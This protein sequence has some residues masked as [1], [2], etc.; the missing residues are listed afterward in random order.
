MIPG[1]GP[2][3]PD[4]RS[5]WN[6]IASRRSP[7]SDT[8]RQ[9][10]PGIVPL[11]FPEHAQAGM[12]LASELAGHRLDGLV[13]LGDGAVVGL[14]LDLEVGR[15]EAAQRELVGPV[16]DLVEQRE[17]AHGAHAGAGLPR[18]PA[19]APCRAPAAR[20][21]PPAAAGRP[22][23]GARSTRLARRRARSAWRRA[24]CSSGTA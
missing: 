19:P 20:A 4:P 1:G 21:T 11:L 2:S 10:G 18:P 13:H 8:R 24:C 12:T 7:T 3:P 23:R 17:P 5:Q 15:P 9:R 14:L 22:V 6:S 16:G